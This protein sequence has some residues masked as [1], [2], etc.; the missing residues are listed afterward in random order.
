MYY[1]HDNLWP[2][3]NLAKLVDGRTRF[4]RSD[5]DG[6][7][8]SF[9]ASTIQGPLWRTF[10]HWESMQYLTNRPLVERRSER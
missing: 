10:L 7:I 1:C 2:A 3:K 4:T 9:R 8:V 6:V 5:M